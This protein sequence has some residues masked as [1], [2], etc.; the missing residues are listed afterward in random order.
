MPAPI[1]D[2]D[3]LPA[4]LPVP[5]DDGASDHLPGQRLPPITLPATDGRLINLAQLAG[6]C[7]LFFYPRTGQPGLPPLVDNWNAI[8]GARG[9]TPQTKGFRDLFDAFAALDVTVLGLSTQASDYQQ[10]LVGR[11]ALP[12]PLLSDAALAL[13]AAMALPTF[14][15]A[16]QRLFKRMAWVVDGGTVVKVFYPVFPPDQNAS[17]VLNWL[18]ARALDAP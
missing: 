1:N 4:D 9:C 8:A 6:T 10:E 13:T 12:F 3:T 16:G 11:L 5:A 18:R 17:D 2:L 7:V 15:A 14:E